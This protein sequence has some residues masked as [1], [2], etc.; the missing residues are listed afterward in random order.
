MRNKLLILNSF[1][2]ILSFL[3]FCHSVYSSK[4]YEGKVVT[5]VKNKLTSGTY[6][7]YWGMLR[8]TARF[9]SIIKPQITNKNGDIIDKGSVIIQLETTY[10]KA[11]VDN[12]KAAVEAA[13]QDLLTA[14]ENYRRYKNL[15]PTGATSLKIYQYMRA[16]YYTALGNYQGAKADLMESKRVLEACTHIAPFEGIVDKVLFSRGYVAGNPATVEVSQLNPIGIQLSLTRDE[17]NTI[18]SDTP[19]SIS[20]GNSN[21]Q[22]VG[23]YNGYSILNNEGIILLTKNYPLIDGKV[24]SIKV[25][26]CYPVIKF[27]TNETPDN[28]LGVPIDTLKKDKT[29][30]FVWRAKDRKMMQSGRG[31]EPTF[32]VE[33]VYVV[34]GNFKRLYKGFTFM[35]ILKEPGKLE[36]CDVLL[37]KPPGNLKAGDWVTLLPE[38]YIL[39]PG[40]RVKVVLGD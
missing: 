16:T 26:E 1:I 6:F 28:H 11:M 5:L 19:I 36:I 13:K 37:S 34:P 25:R 9:G 15:S 12:S 31:M 14:E 22:P 40:D 2:I 33:K 27:Y 32:K 35:R 38:R 7:A 39:M 10:W 20:T 8:N 30:Y 4:I 3:L 24:N 29:G 17:A 18:T 21:N 23:V